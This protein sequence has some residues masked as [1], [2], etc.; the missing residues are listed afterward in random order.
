MVTQSEWTNLSNVLHGYPPAIYMCIFILY[1]YI[2]YHMLT[3]LI[4]LEQIFIGEEVIS[5]S[6]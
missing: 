6:L 2:F 1:I 5:L 4:F 3:D